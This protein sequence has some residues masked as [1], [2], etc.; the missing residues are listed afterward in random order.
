MPLPYK[1][2]KENAKN[3]EKQIY[4]K[5]RARLIRDTNGPSVVINEKLDISAVTPAGQCSKCDPYDGGANPAK[6]PANGMPIIDR[7]KLDG[8]SVDVSCPPDLLREKPFK[9]IRL[10]D[11]LCHFP[12]FPLLRFSC[13]PFWPFW[14]F[15]FSLP[16]SA[17]FVEVPKRISGRPSPVGVPKKESLLPPPLPP[18]RPHGL[19][20]CDASSVYLPQRADGMIMLHSTRFPAR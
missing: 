3:T 5:R 8:A 12:L 1:L 11:Q 4:E 20:I 2:G 16:R 9:A 13:W 15:S 17:P 19:F 10:G 7:I 18:T 6:G 14:P